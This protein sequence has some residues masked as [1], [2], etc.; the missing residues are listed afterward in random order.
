MSTSLLYHA[1]GMLGYRYVRSDYF[2]D[3]AAFYRRAALAWTDRNWCTA[4]TRHLPGRRRSRQL[5][6]LA[7]RDPTPK[8]NDRSK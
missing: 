8:P 7:C 6:Y 2:E 4:C 1:F 5:R 3:E